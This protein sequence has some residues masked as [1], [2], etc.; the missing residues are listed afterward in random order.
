MSNVD[1]LDL[2]TDCTEFQP[3]IV[4]NGSSSNVPASASDMQP[5][6][7]SDILI[8]LTAD[9]GLFGT[10]QKD[11]SSIGQPS[12]EASILE[13]IAPYEPLAA[14]DRPLASDADPLFGMP[15]DP[16]VFDAIPQSAVDTLA[17]TTDPVVFDAIPVKTP[18][19]APA[20]FDVPVSQTPPIS[21]DP[22]VFDAVPPIDSNQL[23]FDTMPGYQALS[24]LDCDPILD[25]AE[26]AA[27]S[28]QGSNAVFDETLLNIALD[29]LPSSDAMDE[30]RPAVKD[31]RVTLED[32]EKKNIIVYD[33]GERQRVGWYADT[34]KA[35][36]KEAILCACDAIMNGGFILRQVVDGS[37]DEGEGMNGRVFEFEDFD[38]LESGQS[39]ILEPAKERED[40]KDITGD[41][42]RRLN[43]QVEPLL[44]V[45]AQKAIDSMRRG[46]N[47]LKHTRFGFPHLRQ[48][49]LSEDK[50]RLLWYS[51]AKRKDDSI[52]QVE[53]IEEII[54]GQQTSIFNNYRLPMLEHLSFSIRHLHGKTLDLTCK[55]EFEFDHWVTGLKALL[56]H[57]K[58]RLLSKAELLGHSKRFR[59]AL[60]KNNC[61][62]KLTTLPE[63]REK[64]HVGLDDCIEIVTHTTAQLESKLDRLRERLKIISAQVSKLDFHASAEMELDVA[65]LTGQGP[66]YASLFREDEESQDEE[67]EIRRMM[68]LVEETS[69]ILQNAQN[70]L[71]EVQRKPDFDDTQGSSS[72]EVGVKERKK[73]SARRNKHVDQLLW[74]AEVDLE[75]VEDMFIRHI[76]NQRETALPFSAS[77]ADF[78]ARVSRTAAELGDELSRGFSTLTKWFN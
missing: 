14:S 74:K 58:N 46:A 47:L 36:I 53:H 59:K 42:M 43:I 22:I 57:N 3:G 16:V 32:I 24:V 68:E 78:N 18:P 44:H 17:I 19:I 70:E 1:L 77:I 69:T 23:D 65:I 45:E 64:G 30:P 29:P 41:R 63:V 48:F 25:S 2:Y 75:N 27:R 66:A 15:T 4:T 52:V 56:Y 10:I 51:G 40:L 21:S 55:D 71:L 13:P 28:N 26:T 49:Q 54:L 33:K 62:I 39:Y 60:D 8:D 76:D 37:P 6:T 35:D 38:Q 72:T 61:A 12:R 50:R 20:V 9:A 73:Q 34:C 67:M 7:K 11:A 5:T 31:D